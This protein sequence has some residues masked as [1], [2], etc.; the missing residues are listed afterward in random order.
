L[1]LVASGDL[2][3][4]G[5]DTPAGHIDFTSIDH[6]NAAAGSHRHSHARGPAGRLQTSPI[7][8]KRENRNVNKR[9]LLV[10]L[11]FMALVAQAA[12]TPEVTQEKV[13]AALPE[14]EKLAEQAMEKTGIPGMAIAVVYKDQVV[15]LKGFGVRVAGK[16]ETVD[17]DTVFQL[18]SVSKPIA[19]TVVAA[20]VGEKMVRWDD[21]IIKHDPS[22]QM[23]DSW[24][25]REVTLRDMFA[26]RSGLP[27]HAGDRL[28]DIGFDRAAI[29]FRL[30]YQKPDSS[31][32]SHYAYTNFGLTEA[33]VAAAKAAGKSWEDVA[34]EKVYQPLGMK[35]TSSRYA[36]FI[37]AKN[38]ALG[39]VFFDGKWVAKY[40][41]DP[42]AQSP[43]GGV[44]STVRD[45][46]QWVR[47]QLGNGKLDGKQVI[48]AEALAETHR[49]QMASYIA[50][51]PATDRTDFYGL[52][53]G[54]GYDDQGRV[55]WSHSGAFDL[56]AATNINLLPSEG[57]GVVVLTNASPIGVP[58]AI[59]K[60]FYDLVLNGKIERDWFA[61]YRQIFAAALKPD[62]GT[63]IDYANPPKQPSPALPA[64]AYAGTYNHDLFGEMEIVEK[65]GGLAL[66]LGPKKDAF[67]LQHFD[68][69]LFTYQP[70]GENAYGLSAV[71][72]SVGADGKADSVNIENLN[73]NGQGTFA[74]APTT[75]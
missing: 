23:H 70:V 68:R 56:G 57:L 3:M 21:P 66:Q 19:S 61:L 64:E 24:V 14:L 46:A 16:R 12:E 30:R 58:E 41:R 47:L 49:P 31:F 18:A 35:N 2:T 25:T 13:K 59:S 71:T 10:A 9:S 42:D 65:D 39:H 26:H 5:R 11:A 15:Y 54:V 36:D 55:R 45:L 52:G 27:D 20:L 60:S 6:I 53:W 17:A 8:P 28:E 7:V 1:I 43:A 74:R 22:F 44:S 51:D 48:N 32:R 73:I 40:S 38:R 75:N 50:K 29:L 34:A 69:D 63:S 33:A 62:Y 72:F 4:G 67:P 37:A